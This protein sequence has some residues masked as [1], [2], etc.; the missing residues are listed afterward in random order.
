MHQS[1]SGL[2]SGIQERRRRKGR[3]ITMFKELL[4]LLEGRTMILTAAKIGDAL[5]VTIYPKRNG[6]KE[7]N[8]VGNTPLCVT[9]TAEELDH[10]L[11]GLIAGYAEELGKFRSNLDQVKEQLANAATAAA[12]AAKVKTGRKP[13]T[14]PA[15]PAAKSAEPAEPPAARPDLFTASMPPAAAPETEPAQVDA[16]D[17][18]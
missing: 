18:T 7:A 6:E 15:K 2:A 12:E 5:T 11:P 17:C 13:A 14:A 1:S 8:P 10:E 3:G 4:P 16:A 9:G